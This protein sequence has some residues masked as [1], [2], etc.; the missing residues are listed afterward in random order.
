MR[1][2][3]LERVHS[4]R[5]KL[6]LLCYVPAAFQA[7]ADEVHS[8]RRDSNAKAF[9]H[10]G[11]TSVYDLCYFSFLLFFGHRMGIYHI[12]NGNEG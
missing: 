11:I 2:E 7:K 8:F 4:L 9:H 12:S 3:R 1:R 10:L 5:G 6:T